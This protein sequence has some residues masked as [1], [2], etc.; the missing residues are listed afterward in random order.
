MQPQVT[1][2]LRLLGRGRAAGMPA[3]QRGRGAAQDDL[4]AL[5]APAP[6][7]QI[8]R[9]VARPFLLLV[10]GVVFFVHHDQRQPRQA[11]E[12]R[13]ARAQHDARAPAVRGQPAG[14]ALRIRH[15]TVQADH[16]ACAIQRREAGAK[17]RFKLRREVDLGHHHQRLGCRVA[18]QCG[19]HAVQVHLGLATAGAAIQQ[20]GAGLR[21]DLAAHALL[22]CAECYGFGSFWGVRRVLRGRGRAAQAACELLGAEFAQLRRQRGQC[23]FAQAALVV[24]RG[25]GHQ[26]APGGIQ[27]R[28]ACEH[29]GH[30]AQLRHRGERLAGQGIPHHAEHLALAQ[31]HAHQR[32]GRQGFGVLV[33][34]QVAHAAVC[35]GL[36]GHVQDAGHL[37]ELVHTVWQMRG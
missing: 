3:L 28:Q 23:Y 9:R 2:A 35:G 15:A 27:W 10:A 6:Q 29:A 11:G 8:A 20:K 12:H 18:C 13:H 14:Q 1:S 31:G 34:E 24:T 30:G 4:G 32:A 7:R 33:A 36:D 26:A 22:L 25:E 17:A 37:A 16:A 19:L 21:R 5:L